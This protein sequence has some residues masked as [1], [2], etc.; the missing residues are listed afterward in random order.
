MIS[1]FD[2][3]VIKSNPQAKEEILSLKNTSATSKPKIKEC[4]KSSRPGSVQTSSNSSGTSERAYGKKSNSPKKRDTRQ[5]KG[6]GGSGDG[7]PP[8]PPR[9]PAISKEPGVNNSELIKHLHEQ[10]IQLLN[11]IRD[12]FEH[13]IETL[14]PEAQGILTEQFKEFYNYFLDDIQKN[15]NQLPSD[16]SLEEINEIYKE[17]RN[18]IECRFREQIVFNKIT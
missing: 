9:E 18:I 16:I 8:K 13:M 3:L 14:H 2:K 15:F 7:G 12:T 6:S 4:M 5:H 17:E 10:L 11:R 1:F